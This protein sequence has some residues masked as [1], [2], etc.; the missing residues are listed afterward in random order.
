MKANHEGKFL[1]SSKRDPAF[2]SRGFTYWK[3]AT[4]AFKKHQASECHKEASEALLLLPRQVLGNVGEV[5]SIEYKEEKAINRKVFLT[6]LQN[7]SFLARQGMPFRGHNEVSGN[8]HQLLL[9]RSNEIIPWLRKKTDK[10]TSHEIQTECIQIMAHQILRQLCKNIRGSDFYTIMADVCTDIAN[11]EQFT[12]CMRWVDNSLLDH[13]DFIGLYQVDSIDAAT[14]T[15]AIKDTLLR[16]GVSLGQCRGQCYDGAS[17]MS[18]SRSGVSA[19]ILSEEKRAVFMHCYGHALNLAV[20]GTL[21]QSKICCDA[22]EVAFEVTKLINFSPK[23]NAAFDK[24]K[25]LE[26][27][28]DLISGVGIRSF[29]PTRWTVRGESVCS[30]LENY[31]VLNVLWDE[32]LEGSLVPEVKSRIIGVKAQ[33]SGFKLLFGLHLSERI[34]KITDNLSKTLQQESLSAAEAQAIASKTIKTLKDIRSD[35]KFKLF[36]AHVE[37]LLKCTNTEEPSL[38]RKRR[39]PQRFEIG[40]GACH[41]SDTVED[42]YRQSYFEVLDLVTT[43]IEDRFNQPGYLTYKNLEELLI[44]AANQ[45]DYHTELQKVVSFYGSDF[46]EYELSAQLEIF[47]SSF[48]TPGE[49]ITLKEVISFLRS[50]SVGQRA[51]YKQVC[52]IAKLVLVMPATNAA[53]EGSFSTMKRI[54]SYLRSTMKQSRLNNLMMLNIYKEELEKLSLVSVANEFVS[55]SD[56]RTHVFGTFS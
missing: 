47:S 2:I 41:F 25:A 7:I 15:D 9:L 48:P 37:C 43:S 55:G 12:I 22:M 23:R 44:K 24:I 54:K 50:L 10:Y 56:H 46:D 45:K 3:E 29:C 27:E 35:D 38:P 26:A 53:S 51:F 1:T 28:D 5:L 30:I 17:N 13:E 19:R 39:A 31:N 42:Y 40:G 49:T 52:K 36:W 32:C 14:L 6:I 20:G 18:G 11:K 33:M 16:M 21:K 8:F 4:S 34:L